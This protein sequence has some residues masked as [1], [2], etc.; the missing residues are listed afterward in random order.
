MN[1]YWW[2][3]GETGNIRY[4]GSFNSWEDANNYLEASFNYV[5]W[6]FT[7]YPEVEEI[8]A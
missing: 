7:G 5:V 4:A 1:D 3:D 2:L 8:G 6:I